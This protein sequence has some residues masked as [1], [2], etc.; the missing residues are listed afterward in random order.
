MKKW[1]L[2]MLT[3]MIITLSVPTLTVWMGSIWSN[4]SQSAPSVIPL[5]T[6]GDV[7]ISIY[8][9]KEKKVVKVPL[10][11][12][13]RGVVAAE[14]PAEFEL[15]ALKA[16]ALAARTYIIRKIVDEDFSSLPNG[17]YVTDS[18]QDQVYLPENQL[19]AIWGPIKYAWSI[20]KI[21]RAVNETRGL[22]LT[23]NGKPINAT[24]FSTSNG[25]TENSEDYWSVKEPYLR[26]VASPWD[27]TSPKYSAEKHVPYTELKQALGLPLSVPA[28]KQTNFM[29]VLGE[30]SGKRVKT[31]RVGKQVFSGR[32][33]REKLEL[34]SS[35][36]TWKQ[37]QDGINFI[38]YGYGHGVGMSQYGANGMAKEG[39]T[40]EQIV[41][42]YYSGISLT[43][44]DEFA[45]LSDSK[46]KKE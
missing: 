27:K 3:I 17:A 7:N 1:L 12:Y 39:K 22:V 45:Q 4:K 6:S 24:F 2:V 23:Y 28:M 8:L 32:E 33:I 14:M 34:N 37:D 21:N 16:Q 18:I 26:S 38:T 15:E 44:I 30:T 20:G 11:A 5:N 9:T 10:E 25:Y 36:F 35:E 42:H 40:A 43:S 19:K 31:I 46:Q 41:K 29:T 13:V